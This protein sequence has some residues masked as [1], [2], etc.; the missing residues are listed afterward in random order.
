M[1]ARE[2]EE[3]RA[4]FLAQPFITYSSAFAD[5]VVLEIYKTASDA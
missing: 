5:A 2:A 3:K 4:K 1:A